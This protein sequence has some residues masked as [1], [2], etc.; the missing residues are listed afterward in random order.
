MAIL[1]LGRLTSYPGLGT[2]LRK[3]LHNSQPTENP[4][5]KINPRPTRSERLNF[6]RRLGTATFTSI[7]AALELRASESVSGNG[8]QGSGLMPPAPPRLPYRQVNVLI[9]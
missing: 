1:A 4:P 7:T 8:F 2:G 6:C 5:K 9:K 3:R